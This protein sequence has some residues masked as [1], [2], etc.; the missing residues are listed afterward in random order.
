[1]SLVYAQ[2]RLSTGTTA[3]ISLYSPSSPLMWRDHLHAERYS[4]L[5]GH[6]LA[7]IEGTLAGLCEWSFFAKEFNIQGCQ[8]GSFWLLINT[9]LN[10]KAKKNGNVTLSL[11]RRVNSNVF[12][13]KF[14]LVPEYQTYILLVYCWTTSI[15]NTSRSY[16]ISTFFI[17][18]NY[19]IPTSQE[20]LP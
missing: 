8:A 13:S 9:L 10:S 7:G 11:L 2:K 12:N 18:G 1:M 6:S 16:R 20:I 17:F 19:V 15:A 14:G 3:N 5:Y 4:G